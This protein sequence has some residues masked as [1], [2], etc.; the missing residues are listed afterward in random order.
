[1]KLDFSGPGPDFQLTNSQ[2]A[3]FGMSPVGPGCEWACASRDDKGQSCW[4][5]FDGDMIRR[6]IFTG[7]AFY[8]E[9]ELAEPTVED[10]TKILPRTKGKPRPLSPLDLERRPVGMRLH[11]SG[12]QHQLQ[13]EHMETGRTYYSHNLEQGGTPKNL[14]EFA[15]WAARWEA[16]TTQEDLD[17]LTAFLRMGKQKI[18]YREG[19]FFRY[20]LGRREYGYGRILL[21]Y[22]WKRKRKEPF[23]DILQGR[24]P[25]VVKPYR[26]ITTDPDLPPEEL[27]RLPSMPSFHMEDSCIANGEYP[28]AGYLPLERDEL[29]FPVMYGRVIPWQKEPKVVFYCGD[30]Y[31]ELEGEEP[32]PYCDKFR[33]NG[34]RLTM[35]RIRYPL[36]AS[37][38]ARSNTPYWSDYTGYDLRSPSFRYHLQPVC[39]QMGLAP[40]E[41]P[42]N[43]D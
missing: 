10:R 28:I 42:I 13:I 19:D 15:A 17:E 18:A 21:D 38:D 23:W 22:A 32:L 41:L 34:V 33:N 6:V 27:R 14:E 9:C 25:L 31:R 2:R 43:L 35:F 1:M 3:C 37:V 40:E 7:P 30:I 11:F 24:R 4:V 26:I 20:K 16:E 5:C 36:K 12:S 29:D 8:E 39:R